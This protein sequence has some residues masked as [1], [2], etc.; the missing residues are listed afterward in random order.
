MRLKH[1]AVI[2]ALT[3]TLFLYFVS[4]LSQPT[5]VQLNQISKFDGKQVTITG[6]VA[7]YY[8]TQYGN[9][10]ITVRENNVSVIVF[11]EEEIDLEYGDKIQATGQVQKYKGEWEVI[12]ENIKDMKILEK[13]KNTSF[14]VWQL[15]QWPTKYLGLNVNVSGRVDAIF[16]TYFHLKDIDNNNTLLVFYA[17]NPFLY[18][19]ETVFVS[20][21]FL[22]DEQNLRYILTIS[23]DNHGV[24]LKT[25]V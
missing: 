19:G 16:D 23:E 2:F 10:L 18:R 20:G 4:T 17:T 5:I 24:F 7:E 21:K 8:T 25:G 14:P 15:A 3:G 6:T 12:V 22:F 11:L 9:Q 13:W 1:I